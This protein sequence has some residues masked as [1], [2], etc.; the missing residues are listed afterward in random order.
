[1]SFEQAVKMIVGASQ[2]FRDRGAAKAFL[3]P[4]VE[5]LPP[6]ADVD[7][8]I[9]SL[10][11]D[12]FVQDFEDLRTGRTKP[13]D[14]C[15]VKLNVN[16][17]NGSLSPQQL[18]WLSDQPFL[19]RL[20]PK[21][22]LAAARA[23]ARDNAGA[24]FKLLKAAAGKLSDLP[25]VCTACGVL[26]E[27]EGIMNSQSGFVKTR[28]AVAGNCTLKPLADALKVGMLPHAVDADVWEAPFDQWASLMLD[29]SSSLYQL[30]PSFLVLYL[31][32]LGLTASGTRSPSDVM[33]T[34]KTC[35]QRF[36]Q[37]SSAHIILILPEPLEE[38]RFLPSEYFSWRSKLKDDLFKGFE[39]RVLLVDPSQV[40][41]EVGEKNWYAAR[42]WYHAKMPCHPNA[43]VSLGARVGL[44]I[45]RCISVPVKVVVCDLDDTLW[46]GVVGEDGW[47]NL[48]LDVHSS[49]GPYIRLQAFLKRMV[50]KGI[51]L[52]AVS[53]NND[54]DVREVFEKNEEMLLKW[55]DFTMI[56]A[57]WFPKSQNIAHVAKTLGLDLKH[58]CFLDDSPFERDEVRS[59]LPQVIV[60]EL[61]GSPEDYVPILIRSGL[62]HVPV[63]TEEDKKRVKFYRTETA[64]IEEMSKVGDLD[65]F[66]RGLDLK[67]HPLR[68]NGDNIGRVVQLINKTSQFN[69]TNKRYDAAGI[70]RHMGDPEV[71]G[72]CY[73]VAD[74]FGDSGIAS[75]LIAVPEEDGRVYTVDTWVMS[76]RVM[77]RTIEQ[78]VFEHLLSWME[79]RE[80]RL[81]KGVYSP[82]GRN[83]PVEGLYGSL[84]FE[85]TSR[86]E[87]GAVIYGYDV[88]TA[89][90]GNRF[91]KIEEKPVSIAV[92]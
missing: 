86:K 72:F 38:E 59:A 50:E 22:L 20:A 18:S 10:Y 21:A 74:R 71:Y 65:S 27:L 40:L 73:R 37:K 39:S 5:S 23:V 3:L 16:L 89:Y 58:F 60:P 9:C 66:L 91:V 53:K 69:L 76:C 78:A 25:A 57:N 42:F 33:D 44:T 47:Q 67:I 88:K 8:C 12:D 84:G 70:Q 11:E 19:E 7:P 26:G 4:F 56:I 45:A 29:E 30:D 80:V 75:V 28:I 6:A 1:M 36:S 63:V 92:Q 34:L 81:I 46:G 64:R 90:A 31:S 2:A 62:F 68:I 49:G 15:M 14:R 43:M 61:A 82:T 52:V 41:A 13:D 35:L 55:E 54:A 24:S 79:A 87:D 32:S 17:K 48:R 83:V 85:L 51:L 77:G